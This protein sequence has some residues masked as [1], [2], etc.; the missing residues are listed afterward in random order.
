MIDEYVSY[1]N[2]WLRY[3]RRCATLALWCSVFVILVTL[4]VC[5]YVV[6]PF[7]ITGTILCVLCGSSI[8]KQFKNCREDSRT[9]KEYRQTHELS[10]PLG[11]DTTYCFFIPYPIHMATDMLVKVL[12]VVGG[13]KNVDTR[14]GVVTGYITISKKKK[15]AVVFYVGNNEENCKVRAV[16][17]F[18]GN[19]DWWDIFLR[20][21]FRMYPGDDFGVTVANGDPLIAGILDLQGDTQQI[22]Y[23]RTTGGTSLTGFLLGGALFGEAGAI[24]GGMSGKTRT[25]T[26]VRAKYSDELLVRII[27]TNGRIWEGTV[28]KNSDLYNEILVNVK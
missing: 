1:Q 23:S 15:Q 25:Y 13:V 7:G 21:L 28:Q 17:D 9:I 14:H 16:F 24:V 20:A 18:D 11:Q 4:T 10:A 22:A 5:A 2:T 26:D 6:L 12:T 3:N 27:Y 8:V 19:D